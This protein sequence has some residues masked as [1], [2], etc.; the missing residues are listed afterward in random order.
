MRKANALSIRPGMSFAEKK[1]TF[2]RW[3]AA[4][5]AVREA[6]DRYTHEAIR[7]GRV[8]LSHWL[9]INRVRWYTHIET[10]GDDFKIG[11]DMIAFYARFFMHKN[12]NHRGFFGIR[13]MD[14]E[15]TEEFA[16]Y[17][18]PGVIPRDEDDNN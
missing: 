11:N 16:R 6:F 5:P 17:F 13:R 2:L 9:I 1:A 12:P 10:V 7:A 18:K 4:N 14:G 3:D 8:R 15:P